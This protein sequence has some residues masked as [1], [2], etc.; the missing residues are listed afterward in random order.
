MKRILIPL[1][2]LLAVVVTV[3]LHNRS[4]ERI[5]GS[6]MSTASHPQPGVGPRQHRPRFH[7]VSFP[8]AV[9]VPEITYQRQADQAPPW[10]IP[11]G[12]EFWHQLAPASPSLS[13]N[14]D[15]G[16]VIGRVAHAISQTPVN[17]QLKT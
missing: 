1:L 5:P 8:V 12:R 14:V 15:L 2:G 3:S 17:P 16:D 13:A 10:A 11:Y 7:P 4:G 9:P 6:N